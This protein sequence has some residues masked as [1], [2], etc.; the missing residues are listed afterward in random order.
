MVRLR[1]VANPERKWRTVFIVTA[2]LLLSYMIP[3]NFELFAPTPVPLLA[4]DRWIEFDPIWIWPY[5]SYYGILIIPYF[6]ARDEHDMNQMVYSFSVAGLLSCAFF[7]FFPTMLPRGQYV[8]GPDVDA[9]TTLLM[10]TIRSLDNS[11]NCF[12]SMHVTCAVI[13]A[14][15]LS[16]ASSRWGLVSFIWVVAVCYSTVATKQHYVLDVF[17]GVG[18][19]LALFFFFNSCV[20]LED[21]STELAH[22]V[23]KK[24]QP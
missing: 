13:A 22:A 20:Y 12:P 3:N 8:I 17:G 16:R 18:F 10:S 21:A 9:V 24:N 19:G 6:V 5:V 7:L 23:G 2:W 4:L 15:T 11:V 14:L 1:S